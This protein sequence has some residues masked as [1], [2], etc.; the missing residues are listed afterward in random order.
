[1]NILAYRS[2][3]L[4]AECARAFL[5]T[6]K[7]QDAKLDE[8]NRRLLKQRMTG[9]WKVAEGRIQVGDAIFLLLPSQTRPDGYPR[10]LQAGVVT[11][12][13]N[14]HGTLFHVKE[15]VQLQAIAQNVKEFLVDRVPPQGNTALPIWASSPRLE[16]ELQAFEASVAKS[17]QDSVAKRLAR[18][19]KAARLPKR[20]VV[21]TEVYARN[22]DVVAE[23]LYRAN[24]ICGRCGGDAPF[25]RKRDGSPFLEVH[26]VV[27]LSDGGE[28][29]VENAVAT[30]PNCH[31][32]VHDIARPTGL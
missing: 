17:S 28:D 30:C 31:R 12:I 32:E 4:L 29:T 26:H 24:G 22:P 27:R 16:S 3:P 20:V 18:L 9:H 2:L 15:F 8:T 21:T 19:H 11:K 23:V 6:G 7:T 5:V 1:M 25:R 13:D 14:R 10:E